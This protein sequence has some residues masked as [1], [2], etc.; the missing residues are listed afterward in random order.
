MDR[1]RSTRGGGGGAEGR[2][3]KLEDREISQSGE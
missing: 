3:S 2:I 1:L